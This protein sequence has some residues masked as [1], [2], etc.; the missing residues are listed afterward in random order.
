[1]IRAFLIL[2]IVGAVAVVSTAGFRGDKFIK[3]PLQVTPDMK[4]QPKHITQH[5]NRFFGDGRGDHPP[6]PGTIPMGFNLEGRYSQAGIGKN[7]KVSFTGEPSYRD[8]GLIGDVYGDGIPLPVTEELLQRGAERFEIFCAVCHDRSGSGNGVVKALGLT[9]VASLID[10]RVKAQPDGQI[11]S[12]I[13]N[14][15]NTMGAY[16]P[17]IAVDDRWAIVSYVRVLQASQAMSA[18]RLPPGV[19]GQLE[20][21]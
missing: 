15:K 12:T 9:T 2:F 21:K 16:G 7:A 4:H 6:V 18:D 19:K 11:Y 1:M 17:V 8:T 5:G 3:T 20:K 13:T 14:G 10:D